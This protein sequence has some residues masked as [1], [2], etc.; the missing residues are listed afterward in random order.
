MESLKVIEELNKI[1]EEM[2]CYYTE[3]ST[4]KDNINSG[5]DKVSASKSDTVSRITVLEK[6]FL[7]FTDK[8]NLY[9]N[10]IHEHIERQ[11]ERLTDLEAY[12]R[13]NCLLIHGLEENN[14]EQLLNLVPEFLNRTLGTN[15][16]PLDL[17]R[18]HRIGRKKTTGHRAIIVKFIRYQDRCM[19]F[20]NKKMLKGTKLG[21]TE[22][23]C[24]KRMALYNNCKVTFGKDSVWTM[25][26]KVNVF[27]NNKK[28]VITTLKQFAKLKEE[29][30]KATAPTNNRIM[31]SHTQTQPKP[32]VTNF[33]Q[34][35][36]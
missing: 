22:S 5:K 20:N 21:I 14:N 9:F 4:I 16:G 33:V 30:A 31:R 25:D 11:E 15:L 32:Q 27:L 28:T 24:P 29:H 26:G 1:K 7:G 6:S 2:K 18:T 3:L 35:G 19:V 12:S 13:R 23:L 36:P 8:V 17:D 34:D 10:K